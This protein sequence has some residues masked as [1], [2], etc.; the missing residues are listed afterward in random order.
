[1]EPITLESLDTQ[2]YTKKRIQDENVRHGLARCDNESKDKSVR[3][4]RNHLIFLRE[5]ASAMKPIKFTTC[6]RK[7]TYT[8]TNRTLTEEDYVGQLSESNRLKWKTLS[9]EER[10]RAW[11]AFSSNFP[12][13]VGTHHEYDPHVNWMEAWD[14][15][16]EVVE[17]EPWTRTPSICKE[18]TDAITKSANECIILQTGV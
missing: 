3:K 5:A 2:L 4:L 16:E 15:E 10:E 13:E 7:T 1:M 18:I 14:C 11:T 8:F 6:Y 9:H 17:G 12:F